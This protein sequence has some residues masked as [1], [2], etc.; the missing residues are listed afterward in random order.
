MDVPLYRCGQA[1]LQD[2]QPPQM[3]PRSMLWLFTH[4]RGQPIVLLDRG[5]A[6]LGTDTKGGKAKAVI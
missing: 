5:E 6:S 4:L 2:I 3:S 1:A